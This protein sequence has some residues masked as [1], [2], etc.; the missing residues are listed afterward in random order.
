[1]PNMDN[2]L[3]IEHLTKVYPG[4][5]ALDDV[6]LEVRCGE[7]LALVGENGAGKSTLIKTITGAIAPDGGTITFEGNTYH[8]MTPTLSR[9]LGISAIY[10]EFVLCPPL[11]VAENIYMGQRPTA[12]PFQNERMML[13]NAQEI[14]DR[15]QV[16][17]FKA[18][19]LIRDLSVAYRQM[20]E[21]AKAIALNAKLLIMDEPT[22]PLSDHEVEVLFRIIDELKSNGI[23]IIY[24]SHRLDELYRISDRVT[25]MRDGKVITTQDTNDL[26]KDQII[27]HMVGRE[28]TNKFDE[29]SNPLGPVLFE[30]KNLG[31]NGVQP[32]SLT[33]HAGEVLG[34]GGLVGAGRT[35]YAQ[36]LFGSAKKSC[37]ALYLDGKLV[38]LTSPV[39]AVKHGIGMVTED[40]KAT[41]VMLR[42]NVRENIVVPI[43]KRISRYGFVNRKTEQQTAEQQISALRIKTPSKEQLVSNLSGGN[44]QKIALAKWLANDSRV[45][46]LDEPTR[47]IDVGAKK[48]I[49]NLINELAAQGK[50]I[51]IIS[52]DM[53]EIMGITDRMYILY[54]GTN[55][56]LLEKADYT[57]E[58][59]LQYASGEIKGEEGASP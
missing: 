20:V 23:T 37:G 58:R 13:A 32:F 41:G 8:E 43:L 30:A 55:V 56:G 35:E 52:S 47:G 10:Q 25:I 49:Y 21:I 11:R 18:T 59:I 2:L 57:Q 46:I 5:V 12:G 22:A 26:T 48:E 44:Q 15:F 51:I 36:L 1:M 17:N 3:R 19:A 6:S 40:R 16:N 29:R 14:L 53:E 24:I 31:G 34:I 38:E 9:S 45:L 42:M 27:A 7:C 54:E 39:D 28:L 33:L 4:V 50:G